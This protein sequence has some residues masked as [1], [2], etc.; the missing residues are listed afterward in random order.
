M[1]N[2]IMNGRGLIDENNT[3]IL[4]LE[5]ELSSEDLAG[6]VSQNI[7]LANQY[8]SNLKMYKGH[9]AIQDKKPKPLGKPDNRIAVNYVKYLV[10]T[11]NGF[12]VGVP[13]QITLQ[14][15]SQNE[16]LQQFNTANSFSDV[17]TNLAKQSSIYGRTYAFLYRNEQS[18]VRV[19]YSSPSNSFMVY[20]DSVIQK[21][22]YFVTYTVNSNNEVS[23]VIY[24][25]KEVMRFGNNYQFVSSKFHPFNAVP[26]VEFVENEERLP[27]C[28]SSAVTIINAIN[29]GLSQ[30]A[31]DCEAIADTYLFVKGGALTQKDLHDLADN[32][33]INFDDR[34]EGADAKF[35]ERPN[36]D[37]TQ[38]NLLTRLTR[39]LFQTTMVTNLDDIE[40]AM[41]DQSGYA[42]ELKMQA[43]RALASNKERTFIASLRE[44]Y[45]IVFNML[46]LKNIIKTGSVL[47]NPATRLEFQFTRNLPQN[48][49]VEANVAKT[50][51]GIVSKETQLKALPSLVCDPKRELQ[52]IDEE[53]QQ[54]INSSLKNNKAYLNFG[55]E[56]D[57]QQE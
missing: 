21:P 45:R 31:N 12:F 20:D 40:H 28:D 9:Y 23:G 4:P 3:L 54:V 32:R 49:Q 17:L 24:S 43:M 19:T 22:R 39:A 1:E 7:A 55:G 42:I 15:E 46:N 57:E 56:P 18:E 29:E 2:N 36:G 51:E 16:K 35:L 26:A 48:I 8:Q 25:D 6:F 11:F 44:M 50:L 41:S 30:K 34:A 14:D 33:L 27:L 38:E 13:P 37:V 53:H 5:Y 10:N 47:D 52:L